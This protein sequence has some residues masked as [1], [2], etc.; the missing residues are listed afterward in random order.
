MTTKMTCTLCH[1]EVLVFP[2]LVQHRPKDAAFSMEIYVEFPVQWTLHYAT[3]HPEEFEEMVQRCAEANRTIDAMP[4]DVDGT[5]LP[6]GVEVGARY[7]ELAAEQQKESSVT[8]ER[9]AEIKGDPPDL[10]HDLAVELNRV[11]RERD[12][13]LAERDE[14][15]SIAILMRRWAGTPATKALVDRNLELQQVPHWLIDDREN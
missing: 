2:A 13:A 9:M 12:A 1:T 11:E 7:R 8:P 4:R 6:N 5:F 3:Q 10:N 15:R 14:A